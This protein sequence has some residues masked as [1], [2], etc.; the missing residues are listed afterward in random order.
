MK[1]FASLFVLTLLLLTLVPAAPAATKKKSTPSDSASS[2]KRDIPE[3]FPAAD[4]S[5]APAITA[6]SA[7]LLDARTGK[8]IYELNAD[9]H[10]PVASTQKLLTSL[11]VAE[12]GD[13]DRKVRVEASDTWA[14]PT[15]LY[16]KPGEVYSRYDFI[17]VLLVHSMNDVARALARDN[18]GSIEGFAARMNAKAA[19]L[20]MRN[21]NFVNPNGLPAPGQYST[22]RDMAQVA[23]AAYKNAIL[24]GFVCQ[25]SV[26]WHYNDGRVR[27][28]E[29]TNRVLKNYP[30]CNGMK[31]GYTEAA[32]HC[33]ISSASHNGR[34]VIAVV[35]GDSKNIWIDSYKLLA[36]GLS[37]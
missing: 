36:F 29:T 19:Q 13:L 25:K 33:L 21:S 37:S 17:N 30:L 15:M 1:R 6:G 3:A 32:G 24:R 31:T 5:S 11:I 12:A 22:A 9:Q 20:G 14:E 7:I 26:T 18:A 23:L 16:I 34:E 10:R 8:V 4:G 35:L 27:V 28:F 2:S